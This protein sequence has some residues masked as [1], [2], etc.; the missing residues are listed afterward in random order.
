M[1]SRI[2]SFVIL[3]S[4]AVIVGCKK[5]DDT[6]PSGNNTIQTSIL[7]SGSWKVSYFYESGSNH[8]SD[9]NDYAFAFAN[10]GTMTASNS[11]GTVNGTWRIDDDG[12]NEFHMSLGNSSTLDKLDK[13][14]VVISQSNSEI[15]LKDDDT[16]H[17]E[18]LH[19]TK[20]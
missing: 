10:N 3:V 18:E 4:L 14:W 7:V 5:D 20:I 9:F 8:T 11:S 6:S 19:F 17:T 15:K 16:S 1:K 12:S 2:Y 13:G